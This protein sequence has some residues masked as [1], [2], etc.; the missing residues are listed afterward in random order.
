MPGP[1]GQDPVLS[2]GQMTYSPPGGQPE[3]TQKQNYLGSALSAIAGKAGP[4]VGAAFDYFTQL[5]S[6]HE[7]ESYNSREA[8]KARAFSAQQASAAQAFN[9]GE[10]RWAAAWNSPEHQVQ[11]FKAAGL[12]PGLMMGQMSPSTAQAATGSPGASSQ[13][14]SAAASSSNFGKAVDSM[15]Q[16]KAV[17][18]TAALQSTEAARNEVESL[19]VQIDNMSLHQR[20]LASYEQMLASGEL[21]RENAERVRILRD[22]EA[23]QLR[24]SINNLIASTK[25]LDAESKFIAEVQ[26]PNVQSQTSLNRSQKGLVDA[27]KGL[28]DA[29]TTT[30]KERPELVRQQAQS[31]SFNQDLAAARVTEINL[32]N[33]EYRTMWDHIEKV[34][35]DHGYDKNYTP[36]ALKFL[37]HAFPEVAQKGAQVIESW[38]DAG[39]WLQFFGRWISSMNIGRANAY[40]H[41][42]QDE[43][44]N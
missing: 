1:G 16:K 3:E 7:Q 32:A 39:N 28:V 18:S 15:I 36:F 12:S 20:N 5:Q 31:E 23:E 17:D 14:A 13:A 6:Q 22:N 11:Q 2:R 4:I 33:R 29:Q 21:D 35:V 43:K 34:L 24:E 41:I 8:A 40:E 19:H 10:A 26:S 44:K 9:R 37:S 30:E 27:Q 42:Q 25:K 38:L